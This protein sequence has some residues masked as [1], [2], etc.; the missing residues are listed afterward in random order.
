MNNKAACKCIPFTLLLFLGLAAHAQN[1]RSFRVIAFFTAKEDL[2]HIS[3]VHEANTWFPQMARQY[4][5]HY[6]S[7]SD[8]NNLNDTF[9]RHY[10]VVL[11]LDT[12]PE[13]PQQRAAF[14]R[15][16]KKGGAWMGFHF[17]AFALTPSDYPQNWN[18]YHDTLLGS[19]QYKSNVWRPVP[20]I[21]QVEDTTHPA[22]SGL[23]S[24]FRSTPNEWYAWEGKLRENPD[25]RVLLSVHPSSFPLGTGPK[26]YEIWHSGDYPVAWTNRRFHIIYMNM[27][28][29]DMDYD[30]G[31]NR[32]LSST[33]S[34]PEQNRFILQ[35]LIWLANTR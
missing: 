28:H 17:A 6:D 20:A 34:S 22:T 5:F 19:G 8:W 29:N 25:I 32:Q 12:R 16:I 27:G 31:T 7:T 26:P 33:F 13:T 2:A 15:Y 9:L 10:Q 30:G 3:F 23:P 18:W 24:T 35:S 14:E 4:H 21:L 11:F 1:S